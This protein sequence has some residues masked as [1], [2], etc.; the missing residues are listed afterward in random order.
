[1]NHLKIQFLLSLVTLFILVTGCKLYRE[2]TPV[3]IIPN[4]VSMI[5]DGKSNEIGNGV[6]V[7]T[8]DTALRFARSLLLTQMNDLPAAEFLNENPK[9][10]VTIRLELNDKIEQT[11]GYILKIDK[12]ITITGK[13]REGV[14][15]GIQSL[16]QI[17][18]QSPETDEGIRIP[19][20]TI[21]DYPRFGYRGMHLD[22]SR[23]F[24]QID[25]I[26]KYI[27]LI[28]MHKMNV[29]H[30]HL[31]DDQGWRIEIKKYPKL[32]DIG[33][34]RVDHEDLPWGERPDQTANDSATYGG[35]YTQEQI[36]EIVAYASERGVT[37]IP[38][39]EMPGHSAATIASYPELSCRG[40]QTTVPPG[41]RAGINILCAGKDGTFTFLENVLSEVITLFPSKYIHIG[42]D[43]AWKKEW[44][45]CPRCQKRIKEEGLADEHELQSY[46]IRRI[47]RFLTSKG[48]TLIGWDEILEGGLAENATVM[49]W[50][51]EAGGIKAA[52]MNH[53]VIMTPVD[54]CYF[55]YYQSTDKNLEPLAFNGYISLEKVYHA[56]PVPDVLNQEEA[57]H[58][59][60]AQGNVWTEFIPTEAIAEYRVL[61]RMS[62]LREVLWSPKQAAR[63]AASVK[64]GQSQTEQENRQAKMSDFMNRLGT[65]L[66]WLTIEKY[67]FHIPAPQGVFKEMIFLDSTRVELLN[68][69]PFTQIRYTLDGSE[70][71]LQSPVYDQPFPVDDGAILKA[72]LFLKNG[73]NGPVKTVRYRKVQ[74]IPCYEVDES[75]LKQG[76]NYH[77]Y[78]IAVGSVGEIKKYKPAK[79]GVMEQIGLP[80]ERRPEVFAVEFIGY[81][82][83]PQTD[84]YTFGLTSDD[85][86]QFCLGENMI[87]NH[88]GAHGPSAA[89]G[90]IG[91]QKG[92]YPI[93]VGYFDGG[94]GNSL[95]L[96]FRTHHG[97]WK[98]IPTRYL[99][100]KQEQ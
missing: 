87:I 67:H 7:V 34:W 60:G 83:V 72:S 70:P 42:G 50:R 77:Y 95:K 98:S 36:R 55:D 58:V 74:P 12:N 1:M 54:Y 61:P 76:L 2:Q 52:K 47:D 92:Y 53:D 79:K 94:G 84:V 27:D 9:A 56:D 3:S 57:K 32:T 44:E 43:E 65:F 8:R 91:L 17:F 20:L 97:E 14:I 81:L 96:E 51:G 99:F 90:Q 6:K 19:R 25:F 38:E 39:I 48:K 28:A 15:H 24:F 45:T 80:E 88:D 22:V 16:L 46:F 73:L 10:R 37:V 66:N 71:K 59:L 64:Q 69:W 40:K 5:Y 93:Y 21:N 31:T 100:Y 62:A 89:Y 4:P 75:E 18:Q 82:N 63:R 30:W 68:P 11:E 78:E 29:F 41:G 86:S 23:H 49:S 35:Y 33:A 26:K 85:G 13:S